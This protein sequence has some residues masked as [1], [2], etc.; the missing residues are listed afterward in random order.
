MTSVLIPPLTFYS[1]LVFLTAFVLAFVLTPLTARLAARFGW[2]DQPAPRRLHRTPTPRHGGIPLFLAFI[3]ALAVTLPFPRTDEQELLRLFGLMLGL[4]VVAI[5]GAYDDTREL[6]APPQFAAQ[7]LAAGIAVASGVVIRQ[8]PSPFGLA[9]LPLPELFAVAFTLFWIV[10]MMTTINWLDGLDG[11]AAGV[12]VIASAVLFIHTFE[13]KQF[14]LALLPLALAGAALGFLIFNF[15]PAKIFLGSGAYLLG[16]ALAVLSIIGGAKV[17]T[18]LLVL[19]IPILDVA[20][21]ILSRVRAGRSPFEADR[22]HLHHRLYDFRIS[23]RAIVALYYALTATFG[24][25]ALILPSP[26]YKLI[27]LI[28]IGTGALAVLIRLRRS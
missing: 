19:A 27:A 5:V 13:L 25:L 3:A 2:L 10:G 1:I 20:W 26:V 11:L 8:I 15:P 17:A 22:G 23:S 24:A 9:P 16:F 12:T 7:I 21:Q 4:T 6:K 28:V 14:S 18:A